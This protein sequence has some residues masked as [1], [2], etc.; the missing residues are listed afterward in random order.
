MLASLHAPR[1][2]GQTHAGALNL[3]EVTVDALKMTNLSCERAA[4]RSE[5]GTAAIMQFSV[6][7]EELRRR[8]FGG[9]FEKF[10]AWSAS[11]SKIPGS[12]QR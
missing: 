3:R 9:D 1:A 12:R 8:A 10:R 11:Q 5:L 6:V 2:F 7:Y 4:T